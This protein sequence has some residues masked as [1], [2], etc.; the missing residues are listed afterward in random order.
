M[1]VHHH[2]NVM[3]VDADTDNGVFEGQVLSVPQ[4]LRILLEVGPVFLSC[5]MIMSRMLHTWST[6]TGGR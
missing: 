2:S 4:A 3:R 5:H 6:Y 1:H